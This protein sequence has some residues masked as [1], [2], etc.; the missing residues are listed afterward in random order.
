MLTGIVALLLSFACLAER[1]CF[2]PSAIRGLVL[3]IL[4]H[5]ETVAREFVAGMARDRGVPARI[6]VDND[7]STN[8]VHDS[9]ADALRLA[10]TF[11]ALAVL[12]ARLANRNSCDC[13]RR[14]KHDAGHPVT[15]VDSPS[16]ISLR[17][18]GTRKLELGLSAA[19]F[20]VER[21]D[22]S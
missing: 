18:T 22:S 9:R 8:C 3:R 6:P 2:A 19:C 14:D 20:A 4:C 12:L 21:I 11:R 13:R 7:T 1:L 15:T 5:A 10:R 16:A 17:L